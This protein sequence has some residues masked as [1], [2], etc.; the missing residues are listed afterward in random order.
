MLKCWWLD[1]SLRFW[2][3]ELTASACKV[4]QGPLRMRM[5]S[6][7]IRTYKLH[8][9]HYTSIRCPCGYIRVCI[10]TLHSCL[11]RTW[12][13]DTNNRTNLTRSPKPIHY[14]QWSQSCTL[15]A[16]AT[17]KQ[18]GWMVQQLSNNAYLTLFGYLD[19]TSLNK[20]NDTKQNK[21]R[22]LFTSNQYELHERNAKALTQETQCQTSSLSYQLWSSSQ[23]VPLWLFV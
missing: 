22:F 19:W 8:K 13:R 18:R 5:I 15:K 16:C 4:Q 20:I 23:K 17:Q 2:I 12:I 14:L 9:V 3:G 11:D 10:E 21:S 7:L 6:I 1:C